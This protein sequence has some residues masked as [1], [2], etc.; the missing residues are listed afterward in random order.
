M[1]NFI[2]QSFIDGNL[3]PVSTQ[4]TGIMPFGLPHLLFGSA[5]ILFARSLAHLLFRS[6][7]SADGFL[8]PVL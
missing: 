6:N 7:F 1:P 8:N 3:S 5:Y 4:I 2:A